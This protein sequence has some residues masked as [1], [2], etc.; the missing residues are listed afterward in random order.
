[1]NHM[2]NSI[3]IIMENNIFTYILME[4]SL[5]WKYIYIFDIDI[6]W[7]ACFVTYNGEAMY[8]MWKPYTNE[9]LYTY[10]DTYV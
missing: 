6:K 8:Y 3:H 2:W 5:Y 7:R 1:M 4:N 10:S 9:E